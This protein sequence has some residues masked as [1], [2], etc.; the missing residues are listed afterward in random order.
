MDYTTIMIRPTTRKR[1]SRLKTVTR[2]TYDELLNT[3]LDF[4]PS[5]DDEGDYTDEFRASLIRGLTD[6]T[7]GRTY[8]LR[9]VKTELGIE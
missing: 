1:L 8:S 6:I 3:L 2:E 4:V 7:H 9:N 5:F